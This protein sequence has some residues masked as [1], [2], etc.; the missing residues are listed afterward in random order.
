MAKKGMSADD[1]K[2]TIVNLLQQAKRPFT[3]KELEKL[4]A[5]AGVVQQTVKDVVKELTDEVRLTKWFSFTWRCSNP[6]HTQSLVDCDKIGATN[7]FWSFPSKEAGMV[8][9]KVKTLKE[10]E[11]QLLE[12][13]NRLKERKEELLKDRPMTPERTEHLNQLQI[14]K[15]T[16]VELEARLKNAKDNDP[17]EGRKLVRACAEAKA[18]AERWTDNTFSTLDWLKKSCG[19]SRPDAMRQLGIT[20]DFDYPTWKKNSR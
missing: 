1:K 8:R 6:P 17:E 7:W 15:T 13:V 20:D 18:S 5:K 19:M 16:K 9:T 11:A 10:K 12:E 2:A 14:L 4:A 3:L